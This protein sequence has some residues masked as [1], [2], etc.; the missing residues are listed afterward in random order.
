MAKG[1]E[2][3]RRMAPGRQQNLP[4]TAP[5]SAISDLTEKL[6]AAG[7][8]GEQEE[9]LPLRDRIADEWAKGKDSVARAFAGLRALTTNIRQTRLRDV[10]RGVRDITA[11]DDIKG[12]FDKDT[13]VSAGRSRKLGDTLRRQVPNRIN[14]QAVALWIDSGMDD[15]S[16]R[17]AEASLPAGT[18]RDVRHTVERASRLTPELKAFGQ[19]IKDYYEVRQRP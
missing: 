10:V 8:I 3:A 9:G 18:S 15:A 6:D 1:M 13:Q 4:G 7:P 19:Q 17:A 16:L 11:L 14:R 2:H 12:V 5:K